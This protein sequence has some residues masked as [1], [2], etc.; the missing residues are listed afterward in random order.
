[1]RGVFEATE[2]IIPTS[3][4]ILP[5]DL[6]KPSVGNG[7]EMLNS[8]FRFMCTKTID[9]GKSVANAMKSDSAIISTGGP[10]FLYLVDEVEGTPVI[11]SASEISVYPIRIDTQSP[12]FLA[13]AA[14]YLQAGLHLLEG[15]NTLTTL[16]KCIGIPNPTKS[17]VNQAIQLLE[18]T[19]TESSVVD[20]NVVHSAIQAGSES[21]RL[22]QR[23]RGAAL[24]ELERFFNVKDPKKTYAGLQRTYTADGHALWTS[25]ENAEKI[26]TDNPQHKTLA[27][28]QEQS[29]N[30]VKFYKELLL[31]NEVKEIEDTVPKIKRKNEQGEA[32]GCALTKMKMIS[33]EEERIEKVCTCELM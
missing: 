26:N 33:S 4:V 7:E 32:H 29:S 6:T 28:T 8:I 16:A 5:M 2:V 10:M 9:F 24:R 13:V 22:L 3:F 21:P 18:A 1:M 11:P 14:P 19:K 20:F 31:I 30:I 27:A 17:V 15:I 25:S 12:Q 23:I